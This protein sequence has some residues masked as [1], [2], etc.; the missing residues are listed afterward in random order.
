MAEAKNKLTQLIALVEKGERVA[1]C[2]RGQPV[3]T[4]VPANNEERPAPKFG[5]LRGI[6]HMTPEQFREATRPMTDQ[7]V[8]DFIA[9]RY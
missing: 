1:I 9:G 5:T 7:E 4:I 6:V 8:D 2:R 3:I